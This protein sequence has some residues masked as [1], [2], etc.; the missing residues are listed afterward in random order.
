VTAASTPAPAPTPGSAPKA[1]AGAPAPPVVTNVPPPP[2][3]TIFARGAPPRV[4]E[5]ARL[6]G[7]AGAATT[8]VPYTRFAAGKPG[9]HHPA[10]LMLE[11]VDAPADTAAFWQ[12]AAALARSGYVVAVLRYDSAAE[13][14]VRGGAAG[15]HE[16]WQRR[17]NAGIAA[18][19]AD[20]QVDSARIGILGVKAGARVALVHA[21]RDRRVKCVVDYFAG[22]PRDG[23]LI[24]RMPPVEIIA[25]ESTPG[26]VTEATELRNLLAVLHVPTDVHVYATRAG[27]MAPSDRLDAGRAVTTFLAKYLKPAVTTP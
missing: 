9:A 26:E 4:V 20:P 11:G 8:A 12:S 25:M 19:A 14:V 16:E 10:L 17:V 13:T 27:T 3:P 6:G 21:A 23:G 15:A 24:Q 18:L 7:A 22:T 2:S 1:K 5:R